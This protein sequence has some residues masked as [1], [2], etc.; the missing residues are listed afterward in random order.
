VNCGSSRRLEVPTLVLSQL[1]KP[2]IRLSP[3]A[4]TPVV[5][6]RN[7][8][9]YSAEV[10][11]AFAMQPSRNPDS[12]DLTRLLR[13]R[14]REPT[15]RNS[16]GVRCHKKR[17][18][19][20]DIAVFTPLRSIV[21]TE[22]VCRL[23]AQPAYGRVPTDFSGYYRSLERGEAITT[24]RIRTKS[25]RNSFDVT[26]VSAGVSAIAVRRTLHALLLRG[27]EDSPTLGERNSPDGCTRPEVPLK[28]RG[29][30]S[31]VWL[32]PEGTS[33]GPGS[34][35]GGTDCLSP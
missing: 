6:P 23:I 5:P 16:S 10:R 33:Y 29:I 34:S 35:Y 31:R 25:K 32:P 17:S 7:Q 11:T 14:Y 8:H 12:G 13:S 28:K 24:T 22:T 15:T 20:R 26:A 1:G 2:S 9:R 27:I 3:R 21:T 4:V 30:G 19:G 18:N